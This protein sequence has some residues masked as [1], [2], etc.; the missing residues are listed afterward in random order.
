MTWDYVAGF[1]DGEGS[2]VKR[3]KTY[4]I[5]VS[6]T[7]KEVLER[8]CKFTGRG[9]VYPL[10][11]RKDHWKNAWLYSAGR[12]KDTHYI[13]SHIADKLIV[14]RELASQVL[15]EIKVWSIETKKREML[16]IVRIKKA[17][18]FR[19]VGWSYRKIGEKLGIDWGY[20]RRLILFS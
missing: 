12:N 18:A 20:A 4:N 16:K 11:K 7:N 3:R 9:Y 6:Q 1:V 10:T 14:K 15:R 8:I 2:I 13:L 19:R 5:Y 17:R